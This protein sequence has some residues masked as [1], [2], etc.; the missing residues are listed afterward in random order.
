MASPIFKNDERLARIG[1]NLDQLKAHLQAIRKAAE[2]VR[3]EIKRIR[4]K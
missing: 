1:Q 2:H 4:R 3:A